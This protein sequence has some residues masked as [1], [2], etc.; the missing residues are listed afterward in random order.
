MDDPRAT[1][2]P[3]P[4]SHLAQLLSDALKESENLKNQL[5]AARKRADYA[6]RRIQNIE[7]IDKDG[8]R[9]VIEDL[10]ERL[11]QAEQ[12]RDDAEARRRAVQ[13]AVEGLDRYLATTELKLVDARR[14]YA[15]CFES[16]ERTMGPP[17]LHRSTPS[18]ASS[19]G[20]PPQL[21][22]S[23]RARTPSVDA[24][25]PPSKRLRAEEHRGREPRPSHSEPV[26][27]CALSA[28]PLTP[29]SSTNITSI[30]RV[31]PS[32]PRPAL[33]NANTIM[34]SS[35]THIIIVHPVTRIQPASRALI[36]TLTKCSSAPQAVRTVSCF[37]RF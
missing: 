15:R 30:T 33:L 14:A 4:A 34:V 29:H 9:R 28:R 1:S 25:Y 35:L 8:A 20:P 10:E 26:S 37:A 27:V 6:E 11:R 12:A 16:P 3:H 22:G 18:L 23:R 21:A 5:A 32:V 7:Q 2:P 13:D 19:L 17:P 31:V 24:M 36:S